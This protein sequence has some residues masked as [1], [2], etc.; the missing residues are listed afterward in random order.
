M[1]GC[2]VWLQLEKIPK[3]LIRLMGA[4]AAENV[5]SR[6][7]GIYN[8]NYLINILKY[9]RMISFPL[10]F[11]CLPYITNRNVTNTRKTKWY[12]YRNMNN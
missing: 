4:L 6:Y 2:L 1:F 5:Y 10:L 8:A 7:Q 9:L 3:K 12:S 11:S